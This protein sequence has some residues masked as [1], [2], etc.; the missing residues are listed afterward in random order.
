MGVPRVARPERL[1]KPNRALLLVYAVRR[2]SM[3]ERKLPYVGRVGHVSRRPLE[4]LEIL[5][6][7]AV[8]LLWKVNGK[9]W[10]RRRSEVGLA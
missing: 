6:R 1:Q 10:D 9:M 5:V 2:Y 4:G 3:S 7:R 8:D